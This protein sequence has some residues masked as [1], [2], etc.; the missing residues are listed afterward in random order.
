MDT[1]PCFEVRYIHLCLFRPKAFAPNFTIIVPILFVKLIFPSPI[2]PAS[3][4]NKL[5]Y[6]SFDGIYLLLP[7]IGYV[8]P[9]D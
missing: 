8:S 4:S 7:R 9:L 2:V 5:L 1:Y 6:G 3:V